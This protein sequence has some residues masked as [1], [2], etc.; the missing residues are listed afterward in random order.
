MEMAYG[1]NLLRANDWNLIE[2]KKMRML[3]LVMLHRK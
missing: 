3:E 2:I 1:M